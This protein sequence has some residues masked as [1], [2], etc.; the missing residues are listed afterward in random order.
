[1]PA[2][3]EPMEPVP[4]PSAAAVSSAVLGR[5]VPSSG[6][7]IVETFGSLVKM[8]TFPARAPVAV[9]VNVTVTEH[10]WPCA[11]AD[12]HGFEDSEKPPALVPFSATLETC[13][14]PQAVLVI[15]T[16]CPVEDC[17][18]TT[19]PNEIDV[20]PREIETGPT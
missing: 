3:E 12:G 13:P 14:L 5:P 20:G 1:M 7:S 10:C 11:S 19:L 18:T 16:V 8:W 17:P 15:V 6:I 4:F 2:G 9:G